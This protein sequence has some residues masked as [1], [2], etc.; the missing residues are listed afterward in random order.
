MTVV[1]LNYTR[2]GHATLG[3]D[4]ERNKTLNASVPSVYDKAINAVHLPH[5]LCP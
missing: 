1:Q 5:R 3:G 4:P 2:D